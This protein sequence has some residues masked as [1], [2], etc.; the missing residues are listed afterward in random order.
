MF[1]IENKKKCTMKNIGKQILKYLYRWPIKYRQLA[2]YRWKKNWKYQYPFQKMISVGLYSSWD[3]FPLS[4][5]KAKI[6][7]QFLKMYLQINL[8][9]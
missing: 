5:K 9:A 7:N 4:L 2:K 1:E 8:G 6:F 3:I